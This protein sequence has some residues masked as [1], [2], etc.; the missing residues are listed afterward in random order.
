MHTILSGLLAGLVVGVVCIIYVLMRTRKMAAAHKAGRSIPYSEGRTSA[1]LMIMAVFGSGSMVW[2]FV[3]AGL[4]H[5]IRVELSF[6]LISI[7]I[8]AVLTVLIWRSR[9]TFVRDKMLLTGI[10]FIGLGLLIP[11]FYDRLKIF[12]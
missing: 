2:G 5:L 7:A 4:Y 3:G 9:T 1:S 12:D 8:A 6:F 11:W 10:I